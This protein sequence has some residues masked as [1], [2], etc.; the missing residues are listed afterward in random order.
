M[1]FS[2]STDGCSDRGAEEQLYP[3][4]VRY[5]DSEVQQVVS[6]LLEIATTKERSTGKNI[7][8]LLDNAL[9]EN[10]ISWNNVLCFSADNAAVMMGVR[11]GTAAFIK[12]EIPHVFILGCLCHRLH[13][14][15]E[16][17]AKQLPFSP[18]DMLVSIF[19]YLEKSSK[20]HK[21]YN[22]SKQCAVLRIIPYLN[23]SV[24]GGCR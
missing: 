15:A 3:V 18:E 6:V 22:K 24:P 13:L 23:T 19:Y 21:E 5:F 14:S 2:I 12:K 10:G 8:L 7:F 4:I 9:K 17:G 16:K 11:N 20:R 1:P